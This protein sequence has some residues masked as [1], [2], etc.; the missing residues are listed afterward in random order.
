MS[1]FTVI[2]ILVCLNT[3]FIGIITCFIKKWMH[4]SERL[5]DRA[6]EKVHC[7]ELSIVTQIK[8]LQVSLAERRIACGEAFAAKAD[9]RV[10]Q[11]EA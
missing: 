1:E 7:L 8:A 5:T 3:L 6:L 9:L 2:E 10:F 11:R 4:T